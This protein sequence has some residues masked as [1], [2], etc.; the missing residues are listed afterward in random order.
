VANASRI[1]W[2]PIAAENH[3]IENPGGGHAMKPLTLKALMATSSSG[4][5]RKPSTIQVRMRRPMRTQPDS[6]I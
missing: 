6:V 4:R 3:R 1:V 5:Y 2:F